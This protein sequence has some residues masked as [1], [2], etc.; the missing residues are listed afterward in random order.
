M[1]KLF[2]QEA[3]DE[4]EFRKVMKRSRDK[5]LKEEGIYKEK[6]EKAHRNRPIY[7]FTADEH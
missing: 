5:I 7:W 3:D 6:G 2:S 4:D 1:V